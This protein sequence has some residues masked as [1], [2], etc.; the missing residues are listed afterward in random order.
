MRMP[1]FF[2]FSVNEYK[3]MIITKPL[4]I[5]LWRIFFLPN[6]I[7]YQIYLSK[8]FI[9]YLSN[10]ALLIIINTYKYNSIIRQQISC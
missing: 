2:I 3:I 4:C 9:T 7:I 5:I 1:F 6:N 8:N 10:I